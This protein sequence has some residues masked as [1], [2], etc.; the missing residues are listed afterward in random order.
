MKR[1]MEGQTVNQVVHITVVGYQA[2]DRYIVDDDRY[3]N[4]TQSLPNT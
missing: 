1:S 4:Q 3:L 2:L